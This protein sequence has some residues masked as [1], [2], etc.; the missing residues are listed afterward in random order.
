MKSIIQRGFWSGLLATSAM[1]IYMF[2]NQQKLKES[3]KS[4]LPPSSLISQS[5]RRIGVEQMLSQSQREN[6]SLL[7]H[8][9]YGI[10]CAGI[11]TYLQ[12]KSKQ[13]S[14]ANDVV[15]GA[16]YGLGVWA[17]SYL[18][19]TPSLKM[20]A[21]AYNMP[22]SR[23]LMM[24]MAHLIWGTTLAYTERELRVSGERLLDGRKKSLLGE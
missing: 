21:N 16:S 18:L 10:F 1:T 17:L 22:A 14:E 6:S 12:Q 23:N 7:S 20:R 3:Q 4:P 19:L 5:S 24:V 11:Y 13:D 8:F 2:K 15:K 9:G